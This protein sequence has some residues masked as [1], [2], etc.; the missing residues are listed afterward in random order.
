MMTGVVQFVLVAG[1][2]AGDDGLAFDFD[3]LCG[4][5]GPAVFVAGGREQVRKRGADRLLVFDVMLAER[6]R[7]G[8]NR[9]LARRG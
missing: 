8:E 7:R 3:R 2:S 6:G 1:G 9:T 4:D 5:Q